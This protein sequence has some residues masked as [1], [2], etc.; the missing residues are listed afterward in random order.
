[1]P[2][3]PQQYKALMATE[4]VSLDF[5]DDAIDAIARIAV[6]VNATVEDI[7]ARRLQ[8]VMEKQLSGNLKEKEHGL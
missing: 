5:T 3:L 4:E 6:G 1:V 8:T 2:N 7:V